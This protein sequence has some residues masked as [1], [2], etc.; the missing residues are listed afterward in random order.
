MRKVKDELRK[1][2]GYMDQGLGYVSDK[3]KDAARRATSTS[4]TLTSTRPSSPYR[5]GQWGGNALNL[6][7]KALPAACGKATTSALP[8]ARRP[9]TSLPPARGSSLLTGERGLPPPRKSNQRPRP[10]TSSLRSATPSSRIAV[11]MAV[12][13][14]IMGKRAR[15]G[16]REAPAISRSRATPPV[17]ASSF[18]SSVR[19]TWFSSSDQTR[20]CSTSTSTRS[21]LRK[22]ISGSSATARMLGMAPIVTYATDASMNIHLSDCYANAFGEW[23]GLAPL[24]L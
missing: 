7:N 24:L 15:S 19:T 17:M 2:A 6:T 21:A 23:G 16:R 13:T 8:P 1:V 20:R 12:T 10:I 18:G 22:K 11:I 9:A 3:V 4:G 5:P 14:A